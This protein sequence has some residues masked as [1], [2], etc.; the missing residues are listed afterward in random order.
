[1][2]RNET[3]SSNENGIRKNRNNEFRL[4]RLIDIRNNNLYFRVMFVITYR[5]VR[6]FKKNA[7]RY[8]LQQTVRTRIYK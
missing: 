3:M 2:I 4:Y 6:A 8:E 7:N 1:M 5:L